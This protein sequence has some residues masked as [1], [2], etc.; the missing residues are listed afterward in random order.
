LGLIYCTAQKVKPFFALQ[1]GSSVRHLTVSQAA[2]PIIPDVPPARQ[3]YPPP[4]SKSEAGQAKK[5]G[6]TSEN[7]PF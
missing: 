1:Y 3:N 4:G 5:V 6:K 7:R 2:W